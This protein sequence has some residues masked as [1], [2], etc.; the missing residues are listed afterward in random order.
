MRYTQYPCSCWVLFLASVT[1]ILHSSLSFLV[2]LWAMIT[3][4]HLA[5]IDFNLYS[6][7]IIMFLAPLLAPYTSIGLGPLAASLLSS[8][9]NFLISSPARPTSKPVNSCSQKCLSCSFP[10]SAAPASLSSTLYNIMLFFL[11]SLSCYSAAASLVSNRTCCILQSSYETFPIWTSTFSF[12]SSRS[13]CATMSLKLSTFLSTSFFVVSPQP[14]LE[15]NYQY[16]VCFYGPIYAHC[17]C[18]LFD[19][20][21]FVYRSNDA[22][23]H[24]NSILALTVTVYVYP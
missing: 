4:L 8:Q 14:N 23:P 20:D 16:P 2:M 19:A 9:N 18:H 1:S 24:P 3:F 17:L 12:T 13:C 10:W 22:I 11:F 5:S 15:Q 21:K 6:D 7:S